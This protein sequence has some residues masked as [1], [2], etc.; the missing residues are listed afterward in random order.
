MKYQPKTDK[1]DAVQFNT[2]NFE[3]ARDLA[4]GRL[5]M[6]VS[7][8]GAKPVGEVT[9]TPA[10][11]VEVN[12]WLCRSSGGLLFVL[13]DAHFHDRYEPV[14]DQTELDRLG[15]ALL[16]GLGEQHEAVAIV[17]RMMQAGTLLSCI[18]TSLHSE[19]VYEVLHLLGRSDT[20]VDEKTMDGLID[21]YWGEGPSTPAQRSLSFQ[22]L[23]V[24]QYRVDD[25]KKLVAERGE[26][27]EWLRAYVQ[28][29]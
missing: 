3:K 20:N 16:P 6:H 23:E 4:D 7:S 5:V 10:L 9:T 22:V 25:I 21:R 24:H 27:D 12:D 19:E 14:D 1:F 26:T 8:Y 2:K 18:D 29:L 28:R 13:P 17:D 11:R 15:H